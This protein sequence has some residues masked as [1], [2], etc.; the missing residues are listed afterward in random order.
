MDSYIWGL[1]ANL[2]S[3]TL[4][5]CAPD[6]TFERGDGWNDE[7]LS[8]FNVDQMELGVHSTSLFSSDSTPSESLR[9]LLEETS[10]YLGGRALEAVVRPYPSKIAGMPLTSG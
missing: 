10:I 4:W 8:I 2:M 9:A 7:D 1:E 3:F 6:N 5:N